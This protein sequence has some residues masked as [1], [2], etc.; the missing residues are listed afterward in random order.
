MLGLLVCWL[1][2]RYG[3]IRLPEDSYYIS[4]AAVFVEWWQVLG[5]IAGTLTVN[6]MILL[7]P[8]LLVR[9]VSAIKALQF[10]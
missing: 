4:Q 8:T 5:V 7:L 2:S 9:K 1:Q 10:R 6:F 3:F